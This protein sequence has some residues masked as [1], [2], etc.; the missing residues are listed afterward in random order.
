LFFEEKQKPRKREN[1]MIYTIRLTSDFGL[2]N[3]IDIIME[4]NKPPK[5]QLKRQLKRRLREAR[6]QSN[7][8]GFEWQDEPSHKKSFNWQRE[9]KSLFEWQNEPKS[10]FAW[11]DV[12]GAR[13]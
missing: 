2:Q 9:P 12:V 8:Q 13:D 3:D 1:L 10:L 6:R 11:Y 4:K 7:H 5:K